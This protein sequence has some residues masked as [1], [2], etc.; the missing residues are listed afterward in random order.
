MKVLK[1][2]MRAAKDKGEKNPSKEHGWFPN[3]NVSIAK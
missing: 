2:K 1:Y 3:T